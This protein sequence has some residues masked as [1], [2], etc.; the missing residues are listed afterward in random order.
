[1]HIIIFDNQKMHAF[2][3]DEL[4][5]HD[6]LIRQE[7]IYRRISLRQLAKE[8]HVSPN[9]LTALFASDDGKAIFGK[10]VNFDGTRWQIDYW[11]VI[12]ILKDNPEL[13][14]E[15]KRLRTDLK[16]QSKK[17]KCKS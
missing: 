1:M 11:R 9:T 4:K 8:L 13:I 10:T 5:E 7:S 14:T 17:W 3:D 2:T 15:G 12:Q 6:D 16:F